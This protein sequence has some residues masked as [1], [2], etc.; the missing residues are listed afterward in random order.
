MSGVVHHLRLLALRQSAVPAVLLYL[1]LLAVFYAS[2]AGP[3]VPAGALTAALLVPVSAWLQRLAATAESGP[4]ADVGLVRVGGRR[5]Q[6]LARLAAGL[7]VAAALAVVAVAWAAAA[8]PH[9]YPVPTVLLLLALHLLL[10]LAGAGLGVLVSPPLRVRAGAAVLAVTGWTL[11]SLVLGWLP[12]A[13]PVLE[14]FAATGSGPGER[15]VAV[16]L[17]GGFAAVTTTAGLLL[18]A[19]HAR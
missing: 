2:D 16:L 19:R 9:P 8:N 10:A 12:P 15:V 7:L 5:R 13:G 18:G 4:F 17:A 14:A 6:Q 3:P 1:V 11:A